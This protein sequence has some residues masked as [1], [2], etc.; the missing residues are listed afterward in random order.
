MLTVHDDVRC[1]IAA[2]RPRALTP[3]RVE[4]GGVGLAFTNGTL[5]HMNATAASILRLADG[6]RTVDDIVDTLSGIYDGIERDVLFEDTVRTIREYQYA[7]MIGART[8]D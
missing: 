4:P 6:R 1:L 3:V 5:R 2:E 8:V 7:G